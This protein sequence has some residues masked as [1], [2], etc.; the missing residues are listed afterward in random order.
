MKNKLDKLVKIF[1]ANEN[2][3]HVITGAGVSVASNIRAFRGE[4]GIYNDEREDNLQPEF[5]LSVEALKT[6]PMEVKQFYKDNLD[7]TIRIEP[8]ITHILLAQLEQNNFI[9]G[10][11]TQNIDELHQKSGSKNVSAIHGT[12]TPDGF[13]CTK[14]KTQ[15][16]FE[17]YLNQVYCEIKGCKGYIRPNIVLYGDCLQDE[18]IEK[19]FE[20][21]GASNYVVVMG[22]SLLVS[23]VYPFMNYAELIIINN[24]PTYFDNQAYLVINEDLSVV[25][26][27]LKEHLVG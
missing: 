3:I 10:V 24:E 4:N 18:P 1:K 6:H 25:S 5:L 12:L 15:F 27:Y 8:N 2:T 9:T 20:I 26:K 22:S 16:T 13:Y 7:P 23:T 17:D 11:I 19:A 14:C 21:A